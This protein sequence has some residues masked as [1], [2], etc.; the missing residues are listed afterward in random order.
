MNINQITNWIRRVRPIMLGIFS[1]DKNNKPMVT[2]KDFYPYF[3]DDYTDF[4]SRDEPGSWQYMDA[5]FIEILMKLRKN[6]G[7]P[8][9]ITS[10]YRTKAHNYKVGGVNG[11]AHTKGY[12]VDIRVSSGMYRLRIIDEALKLGIRR[13]GVSKHFIHIDIDPDKPESIWTY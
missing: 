12:A 1:S 6:V 7:L 10:G 9:I 13:I 2:P 11:S 8:F 5:E 3:K 4:A